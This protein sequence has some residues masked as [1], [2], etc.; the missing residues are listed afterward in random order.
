MIRPLLRAAAAGLVALACTGCISATDRGP[1]VVLLD[2]RTGP[3]T[4]VM[5]Q[6]E[7]VVARRQAVISVRN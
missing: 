1:S 2:A 5:Q 6:R 4:A 3:D 7:R